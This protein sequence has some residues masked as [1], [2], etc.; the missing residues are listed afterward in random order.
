MVE[1]A[2]M[3][4]ATATPTGQ[5][6]V[7]IVLLRTFDVRGFAFFTNYLSRKS[8]ELD[9]NPQAALVFYWAELERQVRIEG[10]VEKV[11]P[12]ESDAYFHARPARPSAGRP[13]IA[14]KS[15]RCRSGGARTTYGP[16]GG[17]ISA[18]SGSASAAL[19]RLPFGAANHRILAGARE[20]FARSVAI[21][22]SV[23]RQLA[24]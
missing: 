13:R 18:P 10:V 23:R 24:A 5:P 15:G 3:A 1:P 4:L 8:E 22:P 17:A 7:R 9:T 20:P 16:V 2:A 11:S 14:A 19:G 6:S 21:P 12:E